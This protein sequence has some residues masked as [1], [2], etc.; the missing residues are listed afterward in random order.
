MSVDQ[1]SRRPILSIAL[2]LRDARLLDFFPATQI[3]GSLRGRFVLSGPGETIRQAIGRSSGTIALVASDGVIPARTASLLGQDVARGLTTD[4][5][6]RATL[7]CMVARLSVERGTARP[8]PVVIDTSRAV[9]RATGAINLATERLAL[10]LS[11][12]PKQR[13]VLRLSGDVRVGGS[14]SQPD[15]QVPPAARTVGGVLRMLGDAI[16]GRQGP[17]ATDSDCAA[18][19]RRALG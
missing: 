11:G 6:A 19:T 8:D 17:R 18:L 5:D 7:R 16:G 3:D 4:A 10:A 15:I 12:A 14:I 9:T 2:A 13:S 1:R